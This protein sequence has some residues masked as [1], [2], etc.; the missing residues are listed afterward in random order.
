M[1]KFTCGSKNT[2][3]KFAQ[4]LIHISCFGAGSQYQFA[5][6]GEWQLIEKVIFGVGFNFD[7]ALL[8]FWNRSLLT[9]VST[10]SLSSVLN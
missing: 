5:G 7:I 4:C 2:N 8:V 6:E 10:A 1:C 3:N 9:A